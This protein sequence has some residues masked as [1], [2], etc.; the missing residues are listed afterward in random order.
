MNFDITVK[1][2]AYKAHAFELAQQLPF[3]TYVGI[4][5]VGGD[6]TLHE[7]LNGMLTRQDNQKLPLGLIPGGSGNSL[8]VDLGLTDPTVAIQTLTLTHSQKMD[9][10]KL[11]LGGS[12]KYTFNIV[13][14]GLPTDIGIQAEKWR[15]LGPSRYTIVSLL[16]VL[17]GTQP[18][19][20]KLTLD[21]KVITGQF[22]MII[23]CNTRHSSN[24][25]IAPKAE[26]NDGMIDVLVVR[27][28]ASRFQLLSLLRQIYDGSHI[29]SPLVEYY[30]ASHMT[31]DAPGNDTLNIDGELTGQTPYELQV[32]P[33]AIEIFCKPE[34]V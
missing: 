19:Q 4:I 23:A 5:V 1:E 9:V 33:A 25:T 14:W 22:T 11:N 28:G 17:K 15:W 26:L 34:S 16:K 18:R 32:H 27:H 13:G 21:Q 12:V 3:E 20:A 8:A 6:G 7:V 31:L 30:T 24:M 2:T 29:K 10:A